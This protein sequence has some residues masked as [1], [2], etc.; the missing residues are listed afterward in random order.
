MAPGGAYLTSEHL[1]MALKNLWL[2]HVS[3]GCFCTAWLWSGRTLQNWSP[4]ARAAESLSLPSEKGKSPEIKICAAYQKKTHPV[5]LPH[6]RRILA[7]EPQLSF[8]TW[9]GHYESWSRG[10]G[11]SQLSLCF[12]VALWGASK[13]TVKRKDL[14]KREDN[15]KAL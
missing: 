7:A 5:K 8:H 1:A 13:N 12:N 2:G 10:C 3:W 4:S 11:S 15:P 9:W 14:I 6:Q